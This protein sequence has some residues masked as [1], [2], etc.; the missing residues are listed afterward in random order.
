MLSYE[1]TITFIF[2][3]P[4]LL[5][6]IA[7]LL[8]M[9][10]C[11]C[12]CFCNNEQELPPAMRRRRYRNH[13]IR[14]SDCESIHTATRSPVGWRCRG[15]GC[16]DATNIYTDRRLCSNFDTVVRSSPPSYSFA[17][18]HQSSCFL[19]QPSVRETN[20]PDSIHLME[21]NHSQVDS[22]P[23]IQIVSVADDG[24]EET[25]LDEVGKIKEEEESPSPP[26]PYNAGTRCND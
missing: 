25:R 12:C 23:L 20:T 24:N 1:H 11:G 22:V 18:Q 6:V 16:T 4:G 26:P 2:F 15:N 9:L 14:M 5:C 3:I 10:T 19:K 21:S 7:G 8:S 17:M 13:H